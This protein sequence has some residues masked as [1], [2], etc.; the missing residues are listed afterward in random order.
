MEPTLLP[1]RVLA[2]LVAGI[3]IAIAGPLI[4]WFFRDRRERGA[5]LAGLGFE[6]VTAASR[7]DQI[8]VDRRRRSMA[9]RST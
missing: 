6:P 9:K 7:T 2:A 3:L 1:D 4:W 8:F 5:E